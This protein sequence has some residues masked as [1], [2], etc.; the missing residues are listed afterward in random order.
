M[1]VHSCCGLGFCILPSWPLS[2]GC[3]D[4]RSRDK[5]N[6]RRVCLVV[7]DILGLDLILPLPCLEV[8]S[9][10]IQILVCVLCSCRGV[11]V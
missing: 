2:A 4:S 6:L 9:P 1:L 11:F 10:L 5:G 3:R 7:A 8:F